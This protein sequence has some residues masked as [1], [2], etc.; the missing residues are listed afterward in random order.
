M[1]TITATQKQ[2]RPR[3]VLQR[4]PTLASWAELLSRYPDSFDM[5]D[6]I[7]QEVDDLRE[8]DRYCYIHDLDLEEL[9]S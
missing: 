9:G 6:D 4:R 2:P 8:I 3:R 1:S 5:D 7:V